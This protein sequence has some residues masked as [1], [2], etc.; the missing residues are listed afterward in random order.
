MM[1]LPH[2]GQDSTKIILNWMNLPATAPL[3]PSGHW[4]LASDHAAGTGLA[5]AW[6]EAT[7]RGILIGILD[8]GVN[9]AHL[10]L[11]DSYDH[12]YFAILAA[13][14]ELNADAVGRNLT[15][16]HGT[17]VAGLISGAIDNSIAGMGGAPDARLVATYMDLSGPLLVSEVATLLTAQSAFD[18]SN[19]SWGFSRA[20]ADNF[21][22]LSLQPVANA[23]SQIV[24]T[25]REG[26]GT[27]LVVAG[28]N[29][30]L[31][32][33]GQNI[34][35]DSNFHNF[36]NSRHTIAVAA[37]DASGAVA[38]FSSPGAN[39]LLAAPGQGLITADGLTAGASG[40]AIVSGT[41]F[42]TPLVSSATALMLEV[43]PALGYRDVQEILAVT[44]R[45]TL[46]GG[47]FANAGQGVNGG[48]LVFDRDIGFGVLDA[49]AAVRLARHWSVTSSAVNETSI[50]VS[51]GAALTANRLFQSMAAD[52]AAP[53]DRLRIEW[54][55]LGLTL[56]DTALR[57][58]AIDIVSPAG[59]RSTIA[60]N[61]NAAGS[62]TFLNF[63]FSTA[64]LR[65][66]DI[67]GT[68]RVELRHPSAPSSFVIY[69]ATLTFHGGA[70]QS[71]GDVIITSAFADLAAAEAARRELGQDGFDA[72]RFN[73]AATDLSLDLDFG[74]GTGRIGGVEVTLASAFTTVIGGA[75]GDRLVAAPSGGRLL[76]ETGDDTIV[77]GVGRDDL[78]GGAG[79]DLLDYGR[80]TT[81]IF[82]SLAN[83]QLSGGMAMHDR[84][85]GFENVL[86]G[87]GRDE[88]VGDNRAN[89][90]FGG[91]GN[92]TLQGAAGADTLDGGDG[93]DFISYGNTRIAVHVD[94]AA[95]TGQGGDAMG[96]IITGIE[97]VI[98]GLGHDTLV[99][100][101]DNNLL[102]GNRGAD[103]MAGGAG[104]DTYR[105]DN[106]NDQVIET[107]SDGSDAGG[108]DRVLSGVSFSLDSPGAA[109]VEN[110][111]LTGKSDIIAT[112]NARKNKLVG[113]AGDNIL[114]GGV[115]A[116][117]LE[118]GAG[119][120]VFVFDTALGAGQVDRITDF[121]PG[122][123][124]IWLD[125][126]VFGGLESGVLDAAAFASNFTGLPWHASI[127]IIYEAD[128]GRLYFDADG[129]GPNARIHVSTLGVNLALTHAD[130]EIF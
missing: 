108:T 113:N 112:G 27:V 52:V 116:D 37:L 19:N 68:W 3:G 128:A 123:D 125:H 98:G 86:G 121:T 38:T 20:F 32:R 118:G 8:S 49:A 83:G 45:P 33:D 41:S 15:S 50:A 101:G 64:A 103:I 90:L 74:A 46:Q 107:N 31:L 29:G 36:T 115:G 75:A 1:D 30:R 62:G 100:N 63:V 97:N 126:A 109:F 84:I 34:G 53:P 94:L 122:E 96:D 99:G 4:W 120:D 127:R 18:V 56:S 42:A 35:D 47:A 70:A 110:L 102:N 78:S 51:L 111:V 40:A 6:T 129:L 82:V 89:A 81:G 93:R 58:L 10:D 28:G 61:L 92:D 21:K 85:S 26:L 71:P 87:S 14:L 7:G 11:K 117:T 72:A 77:A 9:S 44:A 95:G 65:G 67:A 105:V 88:F 39:L 73:A 48:G 54:V 55:E 24:E 60:P 16:A 124:R 106:V 59:T 79:R 2:Q 25:G 5:T 80:D 66:E 57:T 91:N 23:L 12:D 13:E 43:N 104:N 114:R 69:D 22:T 130:I 76:G 17:Q 119:A